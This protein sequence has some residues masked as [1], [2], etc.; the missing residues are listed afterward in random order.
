MLTLVW[1]MG[2]DS[3]QTA[4]DR[5]KPM[6]KVRGMRQ[7]ILHSGCKSVNPRTCSPAMETNEWLCLEQA[8]ICVPL[9][10]SINKQ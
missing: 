10:H 5:V 6:S 8:L 7:L 1:V 2:L 4:N 9:F 3:T